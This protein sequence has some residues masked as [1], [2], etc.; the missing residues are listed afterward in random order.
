MLIVA[1]LIVLYRFLVPVL[2]TVGLI[3]GVRKLAALGGNDSS[4]AQ[5]RL[6]QMAENGETL[7]TVAPNS[8]LQELQEEMQEALDSYSQR[9]TTSRRM[10]EQMVAMLEGEDVTIPEEENEANIQPAQEVTQ[11]T[12]EMTEGDDHPMLADHTT[13]SYVTGVKRADYS[14]VRQLSESEYY[15]QNDQHLV[16]TAVDYYSYEKRGTQVT[17]ESY[18]VT[19]PEAAKLSAYSL[20]GYDDH[21][22]CVYSWTENRDGRDSLEVYYLY[23]YDEEGRIAEQVSYIKDQ[24]DRVRSWNYYENGMSACVIQT[25][26]HGNLMPQESYSVLYD[27]NGEAILYKRYGEQEYY[28]GSPEQEPSEYSIRQLGEQDRNQMDHEELAFQDDYLTYYRWNYQNDNGQVEKSIEIL[29]EEGDPNAYRA[30]Y[31]HY[32]YDDRGRLTTVYTYQVENYEIVSGGSSAYSFFFVDRDWSPARE[33][34]DDTNVTLL[35]KD[36]KHIYGVKC[37]D[38]MEDLYGV[39]SQ[40]YEIWIGENGSF[41]LTEEISEVEQ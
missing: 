26:G 29:P 25:Y 22:N 37:T 11:P 19:S 27:A 30:F 18:T 5:Q 36:E 8:H 13:G 3:Q 41:T 14:T 7:P 4:N 24:V 21:G 38:T 2:D 40:I 39:V 1:V 9:Q 33:W 15:Y 32:D 31:T 6:Q 17:R 16:L 20:E 10:Q 23:T 34:K 28:E 35:F 12:E